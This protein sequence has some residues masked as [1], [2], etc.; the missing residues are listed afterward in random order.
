MSSRRTLILVGSIALGVIAAFVL[1]NYIQGVKDKEKNKYEN[2]QVI[3]ADAQIPQNTAGDVAINQGLV[4][5]GEIPKQYKPA[6]AITTLDEI[7]GE[8]ALF[9]IPEGI[10]ITKEMFVPPSEAQAS[11]RDRLTKPNWVT[12][13]VSV[14]DIHAV[15]GNLVPGDEVNMMI[16]Y[17]NKAAQN[18]ADTDF[19]LDP[20]YQV[21]YQKVH[22]LAIGTATQLLPGEKPPDT[23]TS[24]SGGGPITF[25][26]PPGA[27][28]I[29][30]STGTGNSALYLSLIPKDY[31]PRPIEP[32]KPSPLLPGQDPAQLTPYGP[33]GDGNS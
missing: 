16:N 14:D 31:K 7:K 24:S 2:V 4:A 17:K 10:P 11:L 19:K 23:G 15:G 9:D 3:K 6:S 22:I 27:A 1:F 32:P 29:I 13:T 18:A 20:A 25:N 26:V 12:V 8:V 33:T 5:T 28:A 30:A 21:L